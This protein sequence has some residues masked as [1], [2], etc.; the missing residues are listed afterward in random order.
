MKALVALCF[1]EDIELEGVKR[2]RK[3]MDLV[4]DATAL[5]KFL[6]QYA[7]AYFNIEGTEVRLHKAGT[8][9]RRAIWKLTPKEEEEQPSSAA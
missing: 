1:A 7:D 8:P 2:T 5:G 6:A 4:Y 9:D 3:D